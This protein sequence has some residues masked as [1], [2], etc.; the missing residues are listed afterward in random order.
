ML[1]VLISSAVITLTRFFVSKFWN[2][3]LRVAR[4]VSR[5]CSIKAS[6]LTANQ[7]YCIK[8]HLKYTQVTKSHNF[9]SIRKSAFNIIVLVLY[10]K[11]YLVFNSDARAGRKSA[12]DHFSEFDTEHTR[13]SNHKRYTAKLNREAYMQIYL[14]RRFYNV[15]RITVI[16]KQS[17]RFAAL[18]LVDTFTTQKQLLGCNQ[19]LYHNVCP[20]KA[21]IWIGGS[22]TSI[23]WAMEST[24]YSANQARL[25]LTEELRKASWWHRMNH[26]EASPER[27]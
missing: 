8:D 7:F 5:A 16:K 15:V 1:L 9:S 20:H 17:K 21:A 6:K 2:P 10:H 19:L 27:W 25:M 18:I 14:N 23:G 24:G 12:G 4:R 22:W 13:T 26:Y 11:S 3:P